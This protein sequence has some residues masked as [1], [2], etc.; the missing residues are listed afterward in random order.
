MVVDSGKA[1]DPPGEHAGIDELAGRLNGA[2][3]PN[4]LNLRS[5]LQCGSRTA[6]VN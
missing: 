4:G 3:T 5:R 2:T 1:V 6:S